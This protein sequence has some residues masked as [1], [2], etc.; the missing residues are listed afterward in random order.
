MKALFLSF[1][2]FS[3][4]VELGSVV[5]HWL[6]QQ[7]LS[8]PPAVLALSHTRSAKAYKASHACT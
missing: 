6:M 3:L 1:A 7:P 2:F 5:N 8:L 4:F